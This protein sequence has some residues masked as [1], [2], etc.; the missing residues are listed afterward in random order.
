MKKVSIKL[1]L[2]EWAVSD[3]QWGSF[4]KGKDLNTDAQWLKPPDIDYYSS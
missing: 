2:R 4:Q 1:G 3:E